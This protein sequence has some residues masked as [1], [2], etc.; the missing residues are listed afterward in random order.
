MYWGITTLVILLVG[1]T[2]VLLLQDTDT[3]PEVIYKTDVEPARTPETPIAE[4]PTARPGFKM[5]Q[6]DDH[7]HEVP[8]ETPDTG[9]E[10]TPEPTDETVVTEIDWDSL[11]D[12]ERAELERE[13]NQTYIDVIA[14][15]KG[16]EQLYKLM[17]E[18]EYPYSPEVLE[19]MRAESWRITERLAEQAAEAEERR[20]KIEEET[21]HVK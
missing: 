6:H 17:T 2:A 8:I 15:L 12:E 19:K 1:A 18:N 9:K 13:D 14:D 5:V 7:W 11:S 3:E 21:S 20:A 16:F 10:E 4:K